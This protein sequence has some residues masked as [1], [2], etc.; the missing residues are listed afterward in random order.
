[1]GELGGW[2]GGV[3]LEEMGE[4]VGWRVTGGCKEG[5]WVRYAWANVSVS[6]VATLFVCCCKRSYAGLKH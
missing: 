5:R 6:D 2:G 1:M 4:V 3:T